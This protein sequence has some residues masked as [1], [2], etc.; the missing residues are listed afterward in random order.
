MFLWVHLVLD[1]LV[2]AA[3]L[4][5]LHLQINSLPATLAEAYVD[6]FLMLLEKRIF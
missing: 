5:D 3:C 1:I 2:N 4:E 6:L